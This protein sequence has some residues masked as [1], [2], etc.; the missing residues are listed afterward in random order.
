MTDPTKLLALIDMDLLERYL[1]YQPFADVE[2]R[3]RS[4]VIQ[5]SE[6]YGR[7]PEFDDRAED[8]NS[9]SPGPASEEGSTTDSV[10]QVISGK[11]LRLGDFIDTDAVSETIAL[12]NP[13][14]V[15]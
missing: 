2:V 3:P 5:Y 9:E 13:V 8:G 12:L 6:P 11:V 14:T 4:G 1:G 10:E 15:S 7:D